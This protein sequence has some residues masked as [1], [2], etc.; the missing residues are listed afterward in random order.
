[1]NMLLRVLCAGL[2]LTGL[3]ACTATHDPAIAKASPSPPMTAA[4]TQPSTDAA[5]V[6]TVEHIARRRGV[7]VVWVH[8]P[9]KKATSNQ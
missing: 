6:A 1:M 5:Y 2:L 7:E 4:A 8:P 3:A 9:K